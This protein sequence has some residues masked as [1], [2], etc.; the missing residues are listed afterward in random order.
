MNMREL[1][2]KIN[3]IDTKILQL[4]NERT[5][6]ALEIGRIKAREK[7]EYYV[8]DREKEVYKRLM[9]ENKGPLSS[10]SAKA[11][12]REIMSAALSLEKPIKVTYLG[13]EATFTHLAALEKFGSS[14]A[15]L[16]AKSITDI[17]IEVEKERANYGVVPIE[18][19]TEG[20]VNHT[21][22][23]FIDSELQICS[24]ISL[25]VSHHLLSRGK[26]KDVKRIYSNPQALGQCRNWIESHLPQA[27]LIEV[28]TTSKGAEIASREKEGAAIASELAAEIYNLEIIGRRIE[29]SAAN[30]TRFLVIGKT[31]AGRSGKDKTSIMFSIRDRVGALYAMLQPFKKYGINLT[32]IESRPSRRKAWDYYF[33]VDLEGHYQDEKVEKALKELEKECR[34]LKILGSYPVEEQEK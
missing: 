3:K 23:M 33:F 8:P 32:K 2:Q 19:S 17:F 1:R 20:V 27:E 16:P 18:N 13:P 4:I 15:L 31:F 10:R 14:I 22:D 6:L 28:S 24:E 7:K 29:D 9:K 30:V 21:L 11:I 34:Y 12:Y 26:L 25:E 5:K